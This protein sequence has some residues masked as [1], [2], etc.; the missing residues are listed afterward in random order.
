MSALDSECE[1][2]LIEYRV[3]DV[4]G[5]RAIF[6]QDPVGREQHGVIRHCIYQDSKDPNPIMP[7]LELP[8]AEE[9]KTFRKALEPVWAVSGAGQAWVL[10]QAA[11]ATK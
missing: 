5:W 1:G 11:A 10:E 8:S 4:V 3:E 9:A 6:D 2:T 7:S